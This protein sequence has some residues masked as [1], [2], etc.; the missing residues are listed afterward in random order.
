[1]TRRAKVGLTIATFIGLVTGSVFGITTAARLSTAITQVQVISAN[2]MCAHFANAQLANA[3]FDHARE[4]TL[5][6]ISLLE[7][8]QRVDPDSIHPVQ[9]GVAYARLALVEEQAGRKEAEQ[10][11]LDN[12]KSWFHR[13]APGRKYTDEQLK[14]GAKIMSEYDRWN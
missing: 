14:K 7:Q 6:E 11:A 3:D 13:S 10:T 9:L 8:L 1:M 5:L 4:A 12:A 2:V